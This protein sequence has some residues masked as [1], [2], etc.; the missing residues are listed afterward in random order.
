MVHLNMT[1]CTVGTFNIAYLTLIVLAFAGFA[2]VLAYYNQ[3]CAEP[4]PERSEAKG[5]RARMA[6]AH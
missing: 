3:T 5:E 2:G 1:R 4:N 6:S